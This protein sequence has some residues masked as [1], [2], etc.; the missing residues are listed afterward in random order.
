MKIRRFIVASALVVLGLFVF[1]R[2]DERDT[3]IDVGA[4]REHVAQ[5]RSAPP[6]ATPAMPADAEYVGI[7]GVVLDVMGRPVARAVVEPA[8]VTTDDNGLFAY[9]STSAVTLIARSGSSVSDKQHAEPGT[10]VVLRLYDGMITEVTVLAAEDDRPLVGI[11]VRATDRADAV[12]TDA[13]GVVVFRNV[14]LGPTTFVVNSA[15]RQVTTTTTHGVPGP[16]LTHRRVLRVPLGTS[17][18]RVDE[19]PAQPTGNTDVVTGVVRDQAGRPVAGARI[20]LNGG[21]GPVTNSNGEFTTVPVAGEQQ[22]TVDDVPVLHTVQPGGHLELMLNT[23]TEIRGE[24]LLRGEPVDRFILK[25]GSK[26]VGVFS[27]E[28]VAEVR[29]PEYPEGGWRS[30][31]IT[32]IA[33]GAVEWNMTTK[34]VPDTEMDLGTIELSPLDNAEKK[35]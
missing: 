21:I 9:E 12:L 16:D 27:R 23:P 15:G 17:P 4:T 28:F 31:R 18:V 1:Y 26:T 35:N 24:V 2:N 25:V 11:P 14:G 22:V 30:T 29:K 19:Q 32:I 6:P 13:A 20:R 10:F 8:G 7:D 34:L 3:S 33:S 5:D